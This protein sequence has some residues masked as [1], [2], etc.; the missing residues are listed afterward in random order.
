MLKKYTIPEKQP[1]TKPAK[2]LDPGDRG[3]LC[4]CHHKPAT[5]LIK[6]VAKNGKNKR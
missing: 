6:G 4:D 1:V 5:T 3:A 2:Y